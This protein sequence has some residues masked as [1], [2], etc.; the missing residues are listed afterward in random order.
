MLLLFPSFFLSPHITRSA[1]MILEAQS[2]EAIFIF[3]CHTFL[4]FLSVLG[5]IFGYD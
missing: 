3:T 4:S 1:R 2:P 5:D